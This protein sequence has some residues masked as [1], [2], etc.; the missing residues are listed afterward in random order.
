MKHLEAVQ[1]LIHD[2][3]EMK[4]KKAEAA[5]INTL[6]EKAVQEQLKA[7]QNAP[8]LRKALFNTTMAHQV[9]G[10]GKTQTT[11]LNKALLQKA[12]L[13]SDLQEFQKKCDDVYILATICGVHP[14]ELET[15]KELRSTKIYKDVYTTTDFDSSYWWPNTLSSDI[16]VAVERKL[17][18]ASM[19]RTI[20]MPSN[21]FKIP[22]QTGRTKHYIVSESIRD[23]FTERP[24]AST[25]PAPAE[26]ILFDAVKMMANVIISEETIEDMVLPILQMIKDDLSK[27]AAEAIED[28]VVN[29]QT[30]AETIDSQAVTDGT[31][32]SNDPRRA[33]NGYRVHALGGGWAVDFA[34]WDS[35]T[36][37]TNVTLMRKLRATLGRYAVSTEDL[38]WGVSINGYNQLLS[39][40]EM[41][42]I[43]KYGSNATLITG[44]MGRFDNI[45][46]VISEFIP[47][48]LNTSGAYTSSSANDYTSILLIYTPGF[49]HGERAK[50][51][52]K[53][54]EDSRTDQKYL[55]TRMRKDFKA[56]YMG[57]TY[58]DQIVGVGYGFP[59]A[60]V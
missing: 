39:I 24:P 27:S 54:G 38:V 42:T 57:A 47:E 46:V 1:K 29:G 4:R 18:L 51:T 11:S 41:M 48:Y 30:S 60:L 35:T 16:I 8:H 23:D 56:L 5:G 25:G 33:W 20:T 40:P 52:L 43:D 32:T 59:N 10:S 45:P 31:L 36:L 34:G 26:G 12:V 9:E 13:K 37:G 7:L 53:M 6:V 55:I 28:A 2:A 44:E 14:T 58:A 3:K 50:F 17:K 22:S 49:A 21:P 15:Y 19:H